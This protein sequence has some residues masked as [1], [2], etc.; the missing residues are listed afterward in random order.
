MGGPIIKDKLFFFVNYEHQKFVH[1]ELLLRATEPTTAY[2]QA[3]YGLAGE[4][5]IARSIRSR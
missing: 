1:R 5:R 2:V 3:G 4:A